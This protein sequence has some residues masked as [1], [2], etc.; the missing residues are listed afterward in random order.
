MRRYE[1]RIKYNLLT[2]PVDLEPQIHKV[3]E[4]PSA[5]W[6]S[7]INKFLFKPK[8]ETAKIFQQAEKNLKFRKPIVAVHIRRGNKK[9]EAGYQPVEAYMSAVD[10]YYDQL[11]LTQK[12]K[13]RRI[14][15][16]TDEPKVIQEIKNNYK[17]YK[18]FVNET[19]SKN[20]SN[21]KRQGLTASSVM[22]DVHL[23]SNC[24]FLVCTFSSNI[25]RRVYEFLYQHY[26]NAHERVFSL[27]N[28]YFEFGENRQKFKVIVD[29]RDLN[30]SVGDILEMHGWYLHVYDAQGK[31]PIKNLKNN[32][33]GWIP[34]Y[35]LEKIFDVINFPGFSNV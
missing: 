5:W 4:E 24:D 23:A 25:G 34:S 32:I 10:G 11:E 1:P 2:I 20:A 27:D 17:N 19:V 16:L 9:Q 31:M 15:L 33:T 35:K 7:E 21:Y 6:V 22:T 28:R 13:Q 3:F 14:Y 29:H 26:M 18:V 12:I 30:T 8:T